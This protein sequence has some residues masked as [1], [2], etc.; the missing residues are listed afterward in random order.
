M[1][2]QMPRWVAEDHSE[3]VILWV[4]LAIYIEGTIGLIYWLLTH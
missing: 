1:R 4:A 3:W 2:K